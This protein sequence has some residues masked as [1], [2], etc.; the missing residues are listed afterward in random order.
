MATTT[1]AAIYVRVS[2]TKQEAEGTSLET[3]EALCRAYAEE[4]GYQIAG[5]YRDVFSGA[6]YRERPDLSALREQVRAGAVDVVLAYALDRLSRNQAHLAILAEEIEDAGSRLEFVT[7]DFENSAVG[8]FIRSAKAFAAEVEREKT[9]ERTNRGRRKRAEDGKPMPGPRPLYGYQW[10]DDD[11]SALA[12][13]PMTAP[14]LQR[15]FRDIAGGKSMRQVTRELTQEGIPTPTGRVHWDIS[16]LHYLLSHEGY[17]GSLRAFRTKRERGRD[18]KYRNPTASADLQIV[19]PADTMPALIDPATFAAVQ[20]RRVRNKAESV[21]NN[22]DPEGA[23]LRG[24]HAVCGYCGKVLVAAKHSHSGCRAYVCRSRTRE[25]DGHKALGILAP[26]LDPQIWEWVKTRVS[27][28]DILRAELE[29]QRQS[30]ARGDELATIDR[31]LAKIAAE[32]S[33]VSRSIAKLDDDDASA[34]LLNELRALA[35]QKRALQAERERVAAEH[36]DWESMQARLDA[37]ATQCET[38]RGNLETLDYQG[39]RDLLYALNVQVKVWA[40]DHTPRF[41]ATMQPEGILFGTS[42]S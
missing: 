24:G 23:L 6:A 18:G 5:V 20:A 36:D 2:T 39:K 9:S 13:N 25:R 42:E 21:R 14:V 29:R 3:Q 1:R 33:R 15:I 35:A 8:R 27:R 38:V 7:E 28:P 4:R 26:K 41:E 12:P 31:G 19:L 11:H 22:P 32:Q 17:I 34:P 40:T 16:S 30:D 37:I 10:R